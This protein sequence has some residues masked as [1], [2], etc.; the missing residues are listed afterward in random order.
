MQSFYAYDFADLC[1]SIDLLDLKEK[2]IEFY[3][4]NGS[5]G[6]DKGWFLQL[7]SVCSTGELLV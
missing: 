3:N 4:K 5:K 1:S 2:D 7:I 6:S